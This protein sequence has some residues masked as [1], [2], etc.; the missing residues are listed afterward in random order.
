MTFL[1]K[2]TCNINKEAFYTYF[3][4][5]TNIEDKKEVQRLLNDV[6]NIT[7]R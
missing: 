3:K 2:S 1:D 5:S 4:L 6:K 7:W